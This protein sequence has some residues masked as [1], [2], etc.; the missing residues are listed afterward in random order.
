MNQTII[1]EAYDIINKANNGFLNHGEFQMM[2]IL[3]FFHVFE[4]LIGI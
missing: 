2:I 1:R 4:M 3:E